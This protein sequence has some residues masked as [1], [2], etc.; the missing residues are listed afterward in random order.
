MA[1]HGIASA[2]KVHLRH[3]T[4]GG[5]IKYRPGERDPRE[6]PRPWT[7]YHTPCRITCSTALGLATQQPATSVLTEAFHPALARTKHPGSLLMRLMQQTGTVNVL[8]ANGFQK[9]TAD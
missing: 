5:S 9:H 2:E 6:L 1:Y 8:C 7:V 4:G 3:T